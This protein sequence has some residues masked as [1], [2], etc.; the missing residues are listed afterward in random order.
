MAVFADGQ[1]ELSVAQPCLTIIETY[2]QE[3]IHVFQNSLSYEK[4]LLILEMY[5]FRLFAV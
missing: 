2:K 3:K 4:K 5:I 1:G